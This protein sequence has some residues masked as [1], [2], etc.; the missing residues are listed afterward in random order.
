[1]TDLFTQSPGPG[2]R[3]RRRPLFLAAFGI[4]FAVGLVG[5]L[6]NNFTALGSGDAVVRFMLW[7]TVLA[8]AVGVVSGIL[9]AAAK[10]PGAATTVSGVSILFLIGLW[11]PI[12][13]I[14]FLIFL[15][16]LWSGSRRQ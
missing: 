14:L 5:L 8:I 10:K 1:V 7:P 11:T 15:L 6:S 4:G 13:V 2:R 9:S 3:P 12:G 16:M